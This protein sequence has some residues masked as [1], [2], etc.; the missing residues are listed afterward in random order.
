MV[1][2]TM[3]RLRAWLPVIVLC[4]VLWTQPLPSVQ[5]QDD[6]SWLLGQIN[7][8]R[9][10]LGLHAYSLNAQL[11]AAATQHSR[12][13]ADTCDVSH[14][15][16]NG[17][18]ATTRARAN[19]Y[20]G[21]WISENIYMGRG[22]AQ[23]A[24]NFW[25]NS[26][27]HYQGLTHKVV[28]EIGIGVA[29]GSCGRGYTLVFGHRGDVSA[30][31]AAPSG[32]GG[33]APAPQ[34]YVPPPPT[35]T[36]TPTFP[37][38]TPSH[39]WTFTPTATDAPAGTPTQAA[40][41]TPTNTPLVLP[42]VPA[43]E[44]PASNTPVVVALVPSV[45]P[46]DTPLPTARPPSRTPPP[47]AVQLVRAE[48]NTPGDDDMPVWVPLALLVSALLLGGVGVMIWRRV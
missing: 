11:S 47:D 1:N 46:S 5:A 48:A 36:P 21:N 38:L 24:W 42:T 10:E 34:V 29:S 6:V 7:A 30:P 31:P 15:E 41:H 19:G 44:I 22:G 9:G 28:N 16:S 33:A 35:F 8:L 45:P 20:T 14:T 2:T 12:Y 23:G 17:S 18:T 4:A 39:T 43:L 13:M 40:T 3:G 27:I 37:T 32:D 26:A 25:T